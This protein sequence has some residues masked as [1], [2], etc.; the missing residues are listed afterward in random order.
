M[1]LIDADRLKYNL[2]VARRCHTNREMY[3]LDQAI[4]AIDAAQT[5][6]CERCEHNGY[7]LTNQTCRLCP[8]GGSPCATGVPRGVSTTPTASCCRC[9]GL[10][11][12]R[13]RRGVRNVPLRPNPQGLGDS[14][15]R[16]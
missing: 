15:A 12:S 11:V 7:Q 4:R 6:S 5:V 14:L 9:A 8:T 16:Q 13:D 2:T 1:R 10:E 3:G